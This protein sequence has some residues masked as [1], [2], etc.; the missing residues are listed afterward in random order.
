MTWHTLPL[1]RS[2]PPTLRLK[3]LSFHLHRTI[4]A[5]VEMSPILPQYQRLPNYG[6]DVID[7]WKTPLASDAN[8]TYPPRHA[9]GSGS[10]FG[11]SIVTFIFVPRWPVKGKTE[12]VL[13][14]MGK[15]KEVSSLV[16][17]LRISS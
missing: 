15:D 7:T 11:E 10:G 3:S 13:A 9:S 4:R 8:D 12:S 1:H 2:T 5:L 17:L 14:V 6:E 16:A